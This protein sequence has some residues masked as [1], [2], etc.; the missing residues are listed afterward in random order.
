M[1]EVQHN[2]GLKEPGNNRSR[3]RNTHLCV[4]SKRDCSKS[5]RALKTSAI[6]AQAISCSKS[7]LFPREVSVFLC[8]FASRRTRDQPR[9]FQERVSRKPDE[10]I[11]EAKGRVGKLEVAIN[12]LGEDDPVVTGLKEAL[13][14]ARLQAQV[15][16]VDDRIKATK[17]FIERSRE[18]I[19]FEKRS[20]RRKRRCWR[21]KPS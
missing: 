7:S 19:R 18:W 15:R 6:L 11:S 21:H 5:F 2:F 8:P 16:P 3:D 13:R 4:G 20:P 9:Q 14:Q 10:A 12:A 17:M 1:L